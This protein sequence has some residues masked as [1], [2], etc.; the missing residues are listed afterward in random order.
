MKGMVDFS[1]FTEL[2]FL[3][4]SLSTISLFTWFIVPYF[5]LAKLMTIYDYTEA[6]ASVVISMIGVTNAIGMV[7]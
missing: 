3:F 6:E 7:G 5:Y 4:M 1:M 2:H